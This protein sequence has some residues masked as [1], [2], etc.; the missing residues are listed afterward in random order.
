M[1]L[2]T[3]FQS[4]F[5]R[6]KIRG[7]QTL[8]YRHICLFL[9][10]IFYNVNRFTKAFILTPIILLFTSCS[11][12]ETDIKRMSYIIIGTFVLGLIGF[13]SDSSRKK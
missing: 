12:I 1:L 11:W 8:Y 4:N 7:A 3:P 2:K 6:V 5:P 10:L 9:T 13:V